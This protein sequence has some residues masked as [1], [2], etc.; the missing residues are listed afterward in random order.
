[1]PR[2]AQDG[3]ND[4]VFD[5]IDPNLLYAATPMGT[6]KSAGAPAGAPSGSACTSSCEP[7]HPEEES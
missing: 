2:S 1:M 3:L 4:L 6:W 5:P 7:F